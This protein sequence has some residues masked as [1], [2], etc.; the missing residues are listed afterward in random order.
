MRSTAV[1][2]AGGV[3]L[4]DELVDELVDE[5]AVVLE[6][7]DE[8]VLPPPEL[9]VAAL[10]LVLLV[11]LG[12][13]VLLELDVVAPP[14]IPPVP[15][16]L[17]AELLLPQAT[18]AVA[19]DA[20]IAKVLVFIASPFRG[21]PARTG[22]VASRTPARIAAPSGTKGRARVDGATTPVADSSTS[23][24]RYFFRP[25][26][27]GQRVL[28][29]THEGGST[30]KFMLMMMGT[31]QG[32]KSFGALPPDDLRAHIRFMIKLNEEL[33]ASGELVDAQG[34][35]GFDQHKTVQAR[36]GGAPVVTDGPFLESK[37]FLAGYWLLECRSLERAVEIAARISTA[38][39]KGGAPMNFPV[40]LRAIGAPPPV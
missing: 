2:V 31:L 23:G 33:R 21:T 27:R 17:D 18:A 26:S 19:A 4:L 5:L 35:A 20:M 3:P 24:P 9:V 16:V 6:L 30:M 39:G 25:M 14:P 8:A 11:L 34:L 38:P 32:M 15:L 12:P 28:R 1:Q 7:D 10:L 40:E 13:L 29:R 37:E 22:A 36:E